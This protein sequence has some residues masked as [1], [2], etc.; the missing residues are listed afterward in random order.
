MSAPHPTLRLL[1]VLQS[2]SAMEAKLNFTVGDTLGGKGE[3]A[4]GKEAWRKPR[5]PQPFMTFGIPSSLP[6][7]CACLQAPFTIS[8]NLFTPIQDLFSISTPDLQNKLSSLPSSSKCCSQGGCQALARR[9]GVRSQSDS[10]LRR[11]RHPCS[12]AEQRRT[13]ELW[14]TEL[15]VTQVKVEQTTTSAAPVPS[16][17]SAA[18]PTEARISHQPLLILERMSSIPQLSLKLI[19]ILSTA[20]DEIMS[21]LS[22]TQILFPLP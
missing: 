8:K 6:P 14:G 1:S 10:A 9:K 4:H 7:F 22:L 15:T 19:Q 11:Q 5:F 13:E 21:C 17:K 3:D 18:R 12:E 16:A 20:K 2:S